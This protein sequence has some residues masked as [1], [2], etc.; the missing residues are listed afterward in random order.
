MGQNKSQI[1]DEIVK[2]LESVGMHDIGALVLP[3]EVEGLTPK[4]IKMLAISVL[5]QT[6][7]LPEHKKA[8]LAGVTG[9]YWRKYTHTPE[10][11]ELC[12]KIS[13]RMIGHK[14]PV[15]V[16]RFLK[17]A[18]NDLATLKEILRQYQIL[19]APTTPNPADATPVNI[20]AYFNLADKTED[21]RNALRK[22]IAEA[23]GF[24]Q[25]SRF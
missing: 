12:A 9:Q 8:Q 20:M 23:W 18:M 6:C 2:L 11:R 7:E 24:G 13:R 15:L 14:L 19:D 16:N 10:F 4:Q 5:D 17:L 21:E 3:V 22:T 1:S 25:A